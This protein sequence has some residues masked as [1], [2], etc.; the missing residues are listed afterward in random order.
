MMIS[1]ETRI[2]VGTC[3]IIRLW[4]ITRMC[5][6]NSSNFVIIVMSC[7]YVVGYMYTGCGSSE[8]R[9]ATVRSFVPVL[10]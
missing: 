4:L 6:H 5:I 10:G 7:L 9:C 1:I 3:A 2:D 8:S